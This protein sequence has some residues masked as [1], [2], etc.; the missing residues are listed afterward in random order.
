MN[1]RTEREELLADLFEDSASTEFSGALLGEIL[2]SA[3]R[4]RRMKRVRRAVVTLA[5][6]LVIIAAGWRG[7]R[8]RWNVERLTRGDYA[9]VPTRALPSTSVV[10]TQPL[11]SG[12]IVATYA[13]VEVIRT[14]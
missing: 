2:A 9:M 5:V 3:R 10:H 6:F 13:S 4:R 8:S 14:S 11:R 12:E 7:L 1:R